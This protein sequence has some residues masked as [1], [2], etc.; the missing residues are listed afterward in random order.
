MLYDQGVDFRF[1][2][3][4]VL[5][6]AFFVRNE[7]LASTTSAAASR[8]FLA[9]TQFPYSSPTVP[10]HFPYSS[11]MEISTIPLFLL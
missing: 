8:A 1:Q 11:P 7:H 9:K 3:A 10:L 4:T 2:T 6:E 5:S